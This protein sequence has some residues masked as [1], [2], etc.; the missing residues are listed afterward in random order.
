M[1]MM[2]AGMLIDLAQACHF[3]GGNSGDYAKGFNIAP[4]RGDQAQFSSSLS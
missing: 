3:D 4:N 1:A 2:T